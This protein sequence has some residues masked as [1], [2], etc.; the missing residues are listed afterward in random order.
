MAL[1]Y[2]VVV[3]PLFKTHLEFV[4]IRTNSKNSID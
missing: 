3:L 1:L 2:N 4:K